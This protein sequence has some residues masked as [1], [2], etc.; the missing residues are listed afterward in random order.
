LMQVNHWIRQV[1]WLFRQVKKGLRQIEG[2]FRQI[3]FLLTTTAIIF[4]P[5]F[6]EIC[7]PN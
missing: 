7:Q 2:S 4:I 5:F 3:R 6:P 1:E